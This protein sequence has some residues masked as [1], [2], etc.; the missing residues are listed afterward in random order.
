M[1]LLKRRDPT[2]E[3]RGKVLLL[4]LELAPEHLLLLEQAL[5]M[6]SRVFVFEVALS[7]IDLVFIVAYKELDL[8]YF[9]LKRCQLLRELL[10]FLPVCSYLR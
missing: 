5:L 1:H 10:A 3:E 2:L 7:R 8:A 9:A 4:A 6:Q